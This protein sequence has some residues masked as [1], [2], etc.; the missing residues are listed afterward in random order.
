M[1][2]TATPETDRFTREWLAS[3]GL[4][5]ADASGAMPD[6]L[7]QAPSWS[8]GS[9]ALDLRSDS[10]VLRLHRL[11]INAEGKAGELRLRLTS[12]CCHV[13][14]GR[15]ALVGA[16][17]RCG[18]CPNVRP[19]PSGVYCIDATVGYDLN[20]WVDV[21]NSLD[22]DFLEVMEAWVEHG[23]ECDPLTAQL[24][25]S[26]IWDLVRKT[27]IFTEA[28]HEASPFKYET[29]PLLPGLQD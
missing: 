28:L 27:C 11:A 23:T 15:W 3:A 22:A 24:Q 10:A 6:L 5:W 7:T 20:S 29:D 14:Y 4:E 16:N 17:A 8:P 12:P 21:D 9:T 26:A 18:S 25:A 19:L 13:P 1:G 2:M